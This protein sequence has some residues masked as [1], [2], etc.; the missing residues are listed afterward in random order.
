VSGSVT[1]YSNP[2]EETNPLNQLG[3]T[4]EDYVGSNA[5]R[6]SVLNER[7]FPA[8]INHEAGRGSAQVLLLGEKVLT[9]NTMIAVIG[10]QELKYPLLYL[11]A[12]PA[13]PAGNFRHVQTV[14][15]SFEESIV[16]SL[17]VTNDFKFGGNF[18]GGVKFTTKGTVLLPFVGE[19]SLESNLE[20]LIGGGR[21]NLARYN[22]DNEVTMNITSQTLTL[23]TPVGLS[24]KDGDM[25]LLLGT[26]MTLESTVSTYL[27]ETSCNIVESLGVVWGQG[28]ESLMFLSRSDSEREMQKI[29]FSKSA[30]LVKLNDEMKTIEERENARIL[31]DKADNEIYQWSFLLD[32]WDQDREQ[33]KKNKYDLRKKYPHLINNTEATHTMYLGAST[34]TIE[35]TS[36]NTNSTL[37]DYEHKVFNKGFKQ[38][39]KGHVMMGMEINA[40]FA[41][42]DTSVGS[43]FEQD[44]ESTWLDLRTIKNT[45]T[46]KQSKKVS[47][48][49]VE[50]DAGDTTCIEIY[51][52]PW[53]GTFV[54]EICGG[55]TMCPHV[56][57]TDARQK[58]KLYT[59]ETP[60][61]LSQSDKGKIVME[62]DTLDV[63]D[64]DV[65][66][67]DLVVELASA[68]ASSPV[69]FNVGS[70][71]LNQP[72]EFS[73]AA[74][75]KQ[76]LTIFYERLDSSLKRLDVV[77]VIKSK[78]D[79][80]IRE[81]FKYELVWESQ[82]PPIL[83]GGS[84]KEAGSYITLTQK[85]PMISISAVN[86]TGKRWRDYDNFK[87]DVSLYY[88]EHNVPTAGW[89]IVPE[90]NLLSSRVNGESTTFLDKE[91]SSGRSSI[92]I[93]A[94]DNNLFVDGVM[95]EFYLATSCYERLEDGT[96]LLAGEMQSGIRLGVVDMSPPEIMSVTFMNEV[97]KPTRNLQICSILFNEPIDCSNPLLQVDVILRISFLLGKPNFFKKTAK[98]YCTSQLQQLHV[99]L[100]LESLE[101]IDTWSQKNVSITM[102]GIY[103][104]FGNRFG[105]IVF[106]EE[107]AKEIRKRRTV[108]DVSGGNETLVTINMFIPEIPQY[109]ESEAE[110]NLPNETIM[111]TVQK[112]ILTSMFPL[113]VI[114]T[115]S[116]FGNPSKK[117]KTKTVVISVTSILSGISIIALGSY[118]ILK[119]R[120]GENQK[121]E[122]SQIMKTDDA[123]NIND[124]DD[125]NIPSSDENDVTAKND[126]D[127]MTYLN[128][129]KNGNIVQ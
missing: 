61:T 98:T 81:N 4:I 24:G 77:G 108:N 46:E 42:L 110:S 14:T 12:P 113:D 2:Y 50:S 89:K 82:C 38:K 54:F 29:R 109:D 80:N 21:T 85:D 5:I 10:D 115:I 129:S 18:L 122:V 90:R 69:A 121:Q 59:K 94:K 93:S 53:S 107:S 86:P 26:V 124:E 91:D 11:Y 28:Q 51:E 56:E 71:S 37:Q 92:W 101:E 58:F 25:V 79:S 74:R 126:K 116:R 44:F 27:N 35:K 112:D 64:P 36:T 39:M 57:G 72:L 17:E 34:V 95:Y 123:K 66:K 1:T 32:H 9:E 68:T 97:E 73:V 49:L 13:G 43:V 102:K 15:I 52:S 23:S 45:K 67:I 20:F 47:V 127:E 84:L 31:V 41:K 3:K 111:K 7:Y 96:A 88:R 55:A 118:F 76:L 22:W 78:C 70:A 117:S 65:T 104:I 100:P 48:S 63:I 6:Y 75:Q 40:G 62:I 99:L 106:T 120:K 83:W 105:N 128:I 103:D 119:H 33:A 114:P 87:V 19:H 125:Y 60:N 8:E 30:N 16:N